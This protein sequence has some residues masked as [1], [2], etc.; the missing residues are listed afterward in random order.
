MTSDAPD[1]WAPLRNL[2]E[3]SIGPP[4]GASLIDGPIPALLWITLWGSL[5]AALYDSLGGSLLVSLGASL[6][7]A[8]R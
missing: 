5:M 8:Q 7:E 6:E 3:D 2:I 1:P 4:L